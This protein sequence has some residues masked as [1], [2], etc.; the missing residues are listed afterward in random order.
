MSMEIQEKKIVTDEK[1]N[2]DGFSP[3][4]KTIL[5]SKSEP[6]VVTLERKEE[7]L[8]EARRS[9]VAWVDASSY[10]YNTTAICKNG[11][12]DDGYKLLEST[13]VGQSM[14]KSII[15]ILKEL[16]SSTEADSTLYPTDRIQKQVRMKVWIDTSNSFYVMLC[17][18]K[19]IF[20]IFMFFF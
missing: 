17:L 12:E 20:L 10:P 13:R 16:Y 18:S 3:N 8:L 6:K 4:E 2:V 7:L 11:D 1:D 9:R 19:I 14:K 5:S 15:P